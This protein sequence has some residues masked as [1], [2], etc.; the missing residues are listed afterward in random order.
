[1]NKDIRFTLA[2]KELNDKIE[3]I[4]S[5]KSVIKNIYLDEDFYLIVE[6]KKGKI[7]KYGPLIG[8]PGLTG[9]TGEKGEKG[10]T[11]PQGERGPQGEQGI[12][13]ET[14]P[15][16]E[17]GIQGETGPQGPQ[18]ERGPE[19]PQGEQGIQGETGPQG[20]A[21]PQG[22]QGVQGE[23]GPEGPRGAKGETGTSITD[24]YLNGYDLMIDLSDG[25]TINVGTIPGLEN[26]G[27]I[28]EFWINVQTG[29]TEITDLV[30]ALN[31][32]ALWVSTD[33][34]RKDKLI[35]DKTDKLLI[36]GTLDS[37]K[38]SANG[39]ISCENSG[40]ASVYN[41]TGV[42]LSMFK[43]IRFVCARNETNTG[44]TMEFTVPLDY[45]IDN[46]KTGIGA[47]NYG[48]QYV[49]GGAVP[50]FGDRNRLNCVQASICVPVDGTLANSNIAIN[51]I[52]SLYGTAATT[53]SSLYV[54]RIY[55]VY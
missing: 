1:M 33:F 54:V 43:E 3:N 23:R 55:G 44:S 34:K 42:D 8:P 25:T 2:L 35:Y 45:P 24:V 46:R 14:G 10:D 39:L 15:Q 53:I 29:Q 9:K 19:G 49:S 18:G 30:T 36:E 27:D 51:Q 32:N 28:S 41:I 4:K 11:G 6:Y 17:Q 38:D 22:I 52:Y 7:K 31:R 47:Q 20:E 12:Q 48:T 13:G 21:G 5:V 26:I 16:G 50:S 37:T 40:Y